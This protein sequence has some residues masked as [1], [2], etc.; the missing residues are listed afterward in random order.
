MELYRNIVQ[1]G[2]LLMD[3]RRNLRSWNRHHEL[4]RLVAWAEGKRLEG[5]L[6]SYRKQLAEEEA[7]RM[8]DCIH[9]RRAA[10]WAWRI[11]QVVYVLF[12]PPRIYRSGAAIGYRRR[13]D[14][15]LNQAYSMKA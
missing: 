13:I 3:L 4:Q 2:R 9:T 1:F 7:M 14:R 12:P 6:R 5:P 10:Y 8:R 15:K 11:H